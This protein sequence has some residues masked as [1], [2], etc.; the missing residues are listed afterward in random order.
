MT[1]FFTLLLVVGVGAVT[2][3]CSS[4]STSSSAESSA[5]PAVCSSTEALQ[6]SVADLEDV[7][8]VENGTAALQEAVTS[9]R[10]ALQEVVDD[11]T[12]EYATQVDGLQAS[13]DALQT[14]AGTALDT[15]SAASLSGVTSSAGALADDVS[16]FAQDVASTC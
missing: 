3:G 6:A 10:S 7:Q 16:A 15:P 5:P 1:R 8:V 14:A 13:F 4:D 12:S 2:A 9:V 11:A